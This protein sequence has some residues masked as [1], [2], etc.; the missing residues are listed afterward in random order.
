MTTQYASMHGKHCLVTGATDGIGKETA[1]ALARVGA[2]VIVVG[3]SRAKTE[4]TVDQIQQ[5]T[6]SAKVEYLLAD[7]SSQAEIRR[8][9]DDFKRNYARLDVLVNNAGAMFIRRKESID[10]IEMT[11]A[12]NHLG[13]FLLTNLLLDVLKASAPARIINVASGSHYNA[14]IEFAE[15]KAPRRYRGT[16]RYGLSKLG[17]VLF[18]YELSRRLEGT[19]VTANALHPGFV[20]TNMGANIGWYV[21]LFKPLI[22]LRAIPVEEGADTVIHL[23]TSAEVDGIT[24]KYFYKRKPRETSSISYDEDIAKRLWIV[25]ERLTEA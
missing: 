18:T 25:S 6:D 15:L 24:G 17:N 20:S 22:N 11:F 12:L 19:G 14:E 16:Q 21:R 8:L 13:Y 4:A 2:S 5:Q 23:A 7:L 3:R 9:A 10:G 1:L